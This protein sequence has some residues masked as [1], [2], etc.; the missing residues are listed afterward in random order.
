MSAYLEVSHIS[1][2]SVKKTIAHCLEQFEMVNMMS[3]TL[4]IYIIIALIQVISTVVQHCLQI[5]FQQLCAEN[6]DEHVLCWH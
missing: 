2:F 4:I 6:S 1:I 3:F 5:L